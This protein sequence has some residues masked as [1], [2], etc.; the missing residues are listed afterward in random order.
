MLVDK[1][2]VKIVKAGAK[3]RLFA[4]QQ[5]GCLYFS[6]TYGI[7]K[8]NNG[9]EKTIQEL[10]KVFLGLP[11]EGKGKEIMLKQ[12][13]NT[14]IPNI[15]KIFDE[16]RSKDFEHVLTATDFIKEIKTDKKPDLARVLVNSEFVT[17]LD[18]R[19]FKTIGKDC[20]LKCDNENSGICVFSQYGEMLAFILPIWVKK[21]ER[22]KLD[23]FIKI[24]A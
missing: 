15:A 17:L 19:F 5:E 14:D 6:D 21:E 16:H 24:A 4:W 9:H 7:Y 12:I 3:D 23:L 20:I 22:E 13:N 2:M 8:L 18:E 1:E 11:E 10:A